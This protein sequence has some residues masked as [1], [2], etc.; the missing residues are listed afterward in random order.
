[1][2]N[3]LA[4]I[5]IK[6]YKNIKVPSVRQSYGIM[7]GLIGVFL[8]CFL[9]VIKIVAGYIS[10]SIAVVSDAF[11]N[12]SDAA[13]SVVTLVGFRLSG[14][15]ADEKHPFGH[16]RVEYIAG[17][18]V[19][20]FII[21]TGCELIQSS[22]KKVIEPDDITFNSVVLVILIISILVK[23]VM[24]AANT[25]IA[26]LIESATI[27]ST[28]IDSISDV[29]VT[30]VV[31]LSIIIGNK[32]GIQID[33]YAGVLVG[34]FILKAGYESARDTIS[35]LL[36]EPP[37]KEFIEDIKNTVLSFDGALGVH[38]IIVHNY[39]PSRIIMSLHVEVPSD[40]NI[41]E[42]HDII[43]DIEN[44]LR[45]KY[46]CSAV[47]HMD[48]VYPDDEESIS[49][50]N[51]V[52]FSLEEID[53]KLSFHDFRIIKHEGKKTRIAFD[54]VIPYN[55]DLSDEDILVTLKS[56][57]KSI[58]PDIATDITIDKDGEQ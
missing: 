41:V 52:K 46:H 58:L 12:L 20:L 1:M 21:L 36:G 54:V 8:N 26:G 53:E 6:D 23:L 13:S 5:F 37:G 7:S 44:E 17:L 29:V 34:F 43:D 9:F 25:R 32:T 57:I 30:G 49:L 47:I 10:G 56:R 14:C 55:Y 35:P 40:K 33:G 3:L 42:V 18:V 38:D 28:A 27:R 2:I 15:E 39:G 22:V 4:R 24:F 50:K 31:L 11:N 19:S 45:Q 16:G 51:M 48:P